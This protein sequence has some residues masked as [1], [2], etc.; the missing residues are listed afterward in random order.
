MQEKI[1]A[2]IALEAAEHAMAVAALNPYSEAEVLELGAGRAV[3]CGSFSPVHGCY[4][5]GFEELEEKD[6][7][8]I[9]TFF[10]RKERAPTFWT[11]PKT[12]PSLFSFLQENFRPTKVQAIHGKELKALEAAPIPLDRGLD[13]GEWALA[14]SRGENPAAKEPGLLASVKLHQKNIRFYL[15]NG[16]ASYTYF[17]EGIAYIPFPE[18]SLLP[19][20]EKEAAQFRCHF[21]ISPSPH[22]PKLYERTLHEPL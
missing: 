22:F 15:E 21:L 5:L 11:V 13:L 19:L 17:A 4:A 1:E 12:S 16:K 2:V 18:P 14:F 3:Y 9:E 10:L 20:Q 6:F 8:Q 7:R